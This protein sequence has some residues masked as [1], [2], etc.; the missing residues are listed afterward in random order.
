[1]TATFSASMMVHMGD[2]DALVSGVTQHYPDVIR[3]ALQIVR[4]REGLHTVAGL[5]CHDHPQGRHLL[6]G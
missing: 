4:M 3:P 6:P 1:M 5:L 2:A